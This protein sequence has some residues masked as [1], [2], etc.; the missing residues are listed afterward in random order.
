MEI[1]R[2]SL[3][4]Y[5]R[6]MSQPRSSRRTFLG[7]ALAGVRADPWHE[8]RRPRLV[9]CGARAL[10]RARRRGARPALRAL[11]HRQHA[12]PAPA[13]RHALWAE[14]PPGTPVGRYLVWSDIPNDVQMRWLD[15]R[16]ARER[17]AQSVGQQQ[18]QHVRPRGPPDLVRARQPARRPLRARR[19]RDGAGRALERQAAERAQRRGRASR[20]RRLVHRS[21]LRQHDELRGRTRGAGDQGGGVPHR[22]QDRR[23]R[24]GHGR[25]GQAQ[26]PLLL[27]GLRSCSTSPTPAAARPRHPRVRRGRRPPARGDGRAFAAMDSDGKKAAAPTASG[28]RG[29]QHLGRLR[30]GGRGL[31][32]RPRVRAGRHAHRAREA[33]R[34][35]LRTSASAGP[36][37][38]RLVHDRQPVALR[39]LHRGP[40]ARCEEAAQPALVRR[41]VAPGPEPRCTRSATST[42]ASPWAS[43][44]RAAPSSA[45]R[46][47]AAISCPATAITCGSRSASRRA[48][49]TRGGVRPRVPHA[50]AAGDRQAADRRARPQPRVPGPGRGPARL[51]ARRR[52]AD[53]RLRQ[54]DAGRADGRRHREHPRDRCFRAGPCWTGTSTDERGGSGTIVWD[55]RQLFAKESS[56]T[57]GSSSSRPRP[58]RRAGHCNT[59]GTALSDELARPR[60]SACRCPAAR[61]IPAPIASA[62]RWRTRPAGAPW[63]WCARI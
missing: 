8:R 21:R 18:R 57:R 15:G 14:G 4:L 13:H 63:T 56:T 52:G 6:A 25:A 23:A 40:G 1:E 27:T 36:S 54:D 44:A 24:A 31:R 50:P 41:R 49:G 37:A 5:S 48:S 7:A 2:G 55:A 33:A 3:A 11:P 58:R 30:L 20:R 42:T 29:R 61:P 32:R 59:M 46:R 38:N 19:L 62:P 12:A 10:P 35:L 17:H 26:R 45:S 16:R 53:D 39:A 28:R 51:P 9:R 22:P 60:R 34:I 47:A 43:C